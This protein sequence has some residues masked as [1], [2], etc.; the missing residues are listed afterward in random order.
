MELLF[1]KAVSAGVLINPG[2]IYSSRHTQSLRLSYAYTT[3]EEFR[4][5]VSRLAVVVRSSLAVSAKNS[6]TG[7]V[8]SG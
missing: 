2:D 7:L 4:R 8:A 6:Y 1:R 5:A 3:P